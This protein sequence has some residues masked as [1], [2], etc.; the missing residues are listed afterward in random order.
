MCLHRPFYARTSATEGNND[1]RPKSAGEPSRQGGGGGPIHDRSIKMVDRATHKIVQLLRMFEEQ[2][3]MTFFPRN[4]I[5]VIYECG[6]ALLKEA[7]T[8]SFAATNKRETAL[9]AVDACLRALRGTSRSWPWAERLANL[10]EGKLNEGK[11]N[12][13]TQPFT[14]DWTAPGGENDQSGHI[15]YPLVQGWDQ[16]GLESSSGVP[17]SQLGLELSSHQ[18]HG[19]GNPTTL[20]DPRAGHRGPEK[21]GKSD[22]R[23]RIP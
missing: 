6:I 11:E 5:H 12:N 14:S 19:L 3:S 22:H 7:T 4:M 13:A 17:I 15:F 2:H 21:Y 9:E 18:T 20:E 23:R 16:A 10:L 1:G 8:V